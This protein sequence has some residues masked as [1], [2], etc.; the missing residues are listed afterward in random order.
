VSLATAARPPSVRLHLLAE[1]DFRLLWLVGLVVFVVRWL[2]MLTVGLFTYQHTGS[3][4]IVAM[5]TLLRLLPMALFGAFFGAAAERMQ[6]RTMLLVV[7]LAM[8]ATSATLALLAGTGHLLV[9]HLGVASFINGVGWATDNPGRRMMIGEVAGPDRMGAAMAIDIGTN[10]ASR[11]LGPTV[12][13]LLL[14][15]V[16]IHGAFMLSVALYAVAAL[17]TLAMRYRNN[18]APVT[19]ISALT[20]IAEGFASIRHDRRMIG[21]LVV[22]LIYNLFA[23]PSTSMVP[24]IAQDGLHLRAGA[25]GLIASMDGVGA[26]LG[27]VLMAIYVRPALFNGAYVGGLALYLA[28]LPA[29]AL[30]GA[31][32]PAGVA[33]VLTGAGSAAYSIMQSTLVYL[34]AAPDMRSRMF[35]ILS[36]CIGVGPLG[37]LHLGW[38]ADVIGAPWATSIVAIEGLLALALTRP[39]W[40]HM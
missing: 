18:L 19:H 20:R 39:L 29:F 38:L 3:P 25:I 5:M 16:G 1:P 23:W 26:F 6:R 2:E 13:G 32:L 21:I 40:R 24:V 33:L 22:T 30:A 34:A 17:A 12:G 7:V 37:F 4:F 11:M 28:A 9:W 36:V 15:T 27:S 10:N 14:A 8:L 31:A 35:G